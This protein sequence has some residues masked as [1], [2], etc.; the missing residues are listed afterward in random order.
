M[1]FVLVFTVLCL[2]GATMVANLW[3]WAGHREQ[4][5]VDSGLR[6]AELGAKLAFAEN[7]HKEKFG[8]YTRDFSR[9]GAMLGEEMPCPLEQANTVL[10]CT[11]Y[12]YRV[13]DG[14]LTVRWQHNPAVYLAFG[15]ADG[16]VDCSHAL[17]ALQKEPICSPLE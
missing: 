5:R 12:G 17:P 9:L 10:A 2:L 4:Q 13:Q 1:R 7:L 14:I 15:L 8:A 6:A 16:S 3:H 11:G